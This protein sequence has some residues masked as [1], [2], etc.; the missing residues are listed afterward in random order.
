MECKII[1][2]IN[3]QNVNAS[4]FRVCVKELYQ[5]RYDPVS[6]N[7]AVLTGQYVNQQ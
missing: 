2:T 1:V 7:Y 3:L 5:I 4:G 6:V